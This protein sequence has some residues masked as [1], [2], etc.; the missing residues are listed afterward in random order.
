[1]A[2][3][4]NKHRHL[5]DRGANLLRSQRQNGQIETTVIDEMF[6][7]LAESGDAENF[8]DTPEFTAEE[9]VAGVEFARELRD[10]ITGAAP[11]EQKDR[12]PVTTPFLQGI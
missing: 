5:V 7:N 8:T 4:E 3:T 1:M 2:Y 12:R 11:V 10:F 6:V 9:I